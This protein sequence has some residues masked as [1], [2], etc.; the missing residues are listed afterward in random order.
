MEDKTLVLIKALK[1]GKI[2][3]KHFPIVNCD[4][5]LFMDGDSLCLKGWRSAVDTVSES[6]LEI[7]NFPENW[8]VHSYSLEQG[9]PY[10]WSLN[11][12]K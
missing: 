5:F 4:Q 7:I 9:Y 1:E 3:Y 2:L 11:F 10:P 6:L 12:K 8:D